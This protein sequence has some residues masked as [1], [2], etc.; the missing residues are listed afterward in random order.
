MF[1]DLFRNFVKYRCV[2]LGL[3]GFFVKLIYLFFFK[4]L[5]FFILLY[6]IYIFFSFFF[7]FLG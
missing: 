4:F 6:E 5:E 2:R 1:K 3:G 7:V